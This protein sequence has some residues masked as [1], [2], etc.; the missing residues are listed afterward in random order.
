MNI[1]LRLYLPA[2]FACVVFFSARVFADDTNSIPSSGQP[3][4][5]DTANQ[6]AANGYLQIQE[7]LHAT[8]L[9]IQ[10]E[11]QEAEAAAKRTADE[12]TARIQVLE[13]SIAAQRTEEARAQQLTLIAAGGFGLAALG[14]MLLM[15]YFQWRAF[16]QLVEISARAASLSGPGQ[17]RGL[18]LVAAASELSAPARAAVDSSNA[19]LLGAV[20][21]LEQRIL[22]MEQGARPPLAERV[23]ATPPGKN[24]TPPEAGDRDECVA[25]LV[26]EGQSLLNA[27][28]A[29]KALE[30]FDTALQLEPKHA[31]AL[32]EKG[33]AL[34]KLGRF[35][36]AIGCYD[37]AIAVDDTTTIAYLH[38]G[39][40]FNR[41]ARYDEALQ[42]YERALQAQE[43]KGAGEKAA[44]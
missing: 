9:A 39:G 42:C 43:K 3:P 4:A 16:S 22:E 12:V 6:A 24:G 37:R 30:C 33:G 44:A 26:S 13:Q 7:Q 25:N 5:A 36:E 28:E 10:E 35:D 21:R 2:I 27:N 11:R 31:G 40:L 18:S 20:E 8:Q 14:I 23:A 34:E 41:L 19:R 1:T 17:G 29:A 32:I 15:L 38:K